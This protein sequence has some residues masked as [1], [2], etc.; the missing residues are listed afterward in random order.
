MGKQLV[1][2]WW[3][4]V[5]LSTLAAGNAARAADLCEALQPLAA[6]LFGAGS[7]LAREQRPDYCMLYTPDRKGSVYAASSAT[8]RSAAGQLRDQMKI[9][10][11][12][13]L[14][15]GFAIREEKGVGEFAF[16]ATSKSHFKL[17]AAG[18]ARVVQVGVQRE[19][20][21]RE[22]DIAKGLGLGRA[23]VSAR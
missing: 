14:D 6:E 8:T 12:G 9:R 21:L 19:P 4:A 10:Q 2:A 16:S 22:G 20:A 15:P 18:P 11:D 7:K 23:L 3:T 17:Q 1:R 13:K 5:V